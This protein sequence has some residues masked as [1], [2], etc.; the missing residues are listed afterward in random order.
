MRP[1]LSLLCSGLSILQTSAFPHTLCPPDSSQSSQP[2][3]G[4]CVIVLCPSCVVAPSTVQEV[5][6]QSPYPV[7]VL[8]L[9]HPRVQQALWAARVQCLLRFNSLS[10]RISSL[11]HTC[12]DRS[13]LIQ[14]EHG[15]LSAD[16]KADC[17]HQQKGGAGSWRHQHSTQ[18]YPTQQGLPKAG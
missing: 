7:G 13:A 3:S 5:R 14:T 18:Q 10:A 16:S 2:S 12:H 8:G 6:L 17:K 11:Q 15:L 1:P 4:Q 9:M